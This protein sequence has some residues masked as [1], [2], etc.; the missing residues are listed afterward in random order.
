MPPKDLTARAAELRR[1]LNF[2]SHRYHVLDSPVVSDAEFDQWL[3]ELLALEQAHPDLRS[4]DSPTQ[5]VGGGVAEGFSRV[6]PPAPILSL[7]N[8]Y[9]ADEVR[10]WL[11]RAIRLDRRAA[12]AEF[13]VEPKMD[14][15]TVVLTYERGVF[16]QGTTR[17]DGET[18]EDVTAN[19]RTVRNLPLRIPVEE[20]GP[21]APRRL[22]VRGEAYIPVA[23]FEAMNERLRQAE[24]RTFLNPRNAAAGALRQLDSSLTATRPIRFLAYAIVSGDEPLPADQSGALDWLGKLGFPV[25]DGIRRCRTLDEAIAFAEESAARRSEYSFEADGMVIKVDD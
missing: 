4:P 19:L 20:G 23:D 22:V 17:G 21:A 2:H 1:L 18:G 11:D 6:V 8:A 3:Q 5:R 7:S 14:G 24:E 15:L 10:A 13:V 9:T 16:S 25:A 12:E